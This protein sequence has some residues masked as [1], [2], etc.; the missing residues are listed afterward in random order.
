[1]NTSK[2]VCPK[3]GNNRFE[4]DEFRATGGRFAKIFDVQNKKFTTITCSRCS[5]TELYK[6]T[7]SQL[8]NI[9]DFLTN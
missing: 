3:C 2:Y 5:Y 4:T 7:T 9:F 8:G 6:G 1:M